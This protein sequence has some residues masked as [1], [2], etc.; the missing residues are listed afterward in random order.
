MP[1]IVVLVLLSCFFFRSNSCNRFS[2]QKCTLWRLINYLSYF[3]NIFLQQKILKISGDPLDNRYMLL[4]PSQRYP[5][6]GEGAFAKE[7]IPPFTVFSLYGGRVLTQKE[8]D[9]LRAEE[10]ELYK[11]N[12]WTSAHPNVISNWKYRFK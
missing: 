9:K 12:Q 8:A 3:V 10:T 7:S 5:A 2:N 11:A 1:H 6:A 4:K